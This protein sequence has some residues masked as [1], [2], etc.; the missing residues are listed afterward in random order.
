MKFGV[1]GKQPQFAAAAAAGLDYI[2]LPL[3]KIRDLDE[4][5]LAQMREEL[6]AL[7]LPAECCNQ[8]FSGAIALYGDEAAALREAAETLRLA[9]SFGAKIAVVGS[10]KARAVPEGMEKAEATDRFLRLMDRIGDMAADA[11]I[12][13]AIEPLNY[14]E[15]NFINTVT[16]CMTFCRTLGNKNVGCL[17]DFFHFYRNG[18]T[19]DELDALRPGELLHAHLAR[20]DPDR[21]APQPEDDEVLAAWAAKLREIGYDRR[22]SLECGWAKQ[23]D[24][25]IGPAVA[26]LRPFRE[27][28]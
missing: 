14:G 5:Q 15:T 24:A 19:L 6:K 26:R 25:L 20:P 22:L 21:G 12:E 17:V 16:D 2:E 9:A 27:G 23:F 11:G 4:G 18:E 10:G 28:K 1:C 8:F 3:A 13:I 7:S